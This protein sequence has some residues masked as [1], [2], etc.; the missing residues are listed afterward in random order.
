MKGIYEIPDLYFLNSVK[1]VEFWLKLLYYTW[2]LVLLA[3]LM[4]CV[5][6]IQN[7]VIPAKDP[8]STYIN[9]IIP[10]KLNYYKDYVNNRSILLDIQLVMKTIVLIFK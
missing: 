6:E 7:Q 8:V 4:M 1:I 3:V 9:E 2:R 10:I 5:S